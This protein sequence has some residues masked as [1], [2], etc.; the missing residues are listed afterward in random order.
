MKFKSKLLAIF[1]T[2]IV[3]T[4]TVDASPIDDASKYSVRIKSNVRYA[5]AEEDAGTSDGAGFLIDR[6]RGW[7]L[8]NAH[9][10][11]YG[12]GDIEVSFKGYDYFDAKPVYIDPELDLAIVQVETENIPEE[13]MEAKLSCGDRALNGLAVAAYGHPHGLT[14]SASRGIISKVRYYEGVDWVQ[15]DAAVNPGNSGGPLIDLETGDVVGINA[16]GLEDTEGLNFA[17]PAKPVCKV[18]ELMMANENPSPPELPI[19]FAVNEESEE[20]LIVGA[21]TKGKL[22]EGFVLGD[23]IIN[24]DGQKVETPTTLK[25]N[26]RGK[27]GQADV[28]LKRGEKEVK[29]VLSFLPEPKILDRQYVLADGALIARDVYPERRNLES[30]FL[31]QSVR[32]GSYAARSGWK[33]YRL[34]MSIDG[35]QP[36]SLPQIKELLTG[37]ENKV[38]IF[39]GWSAQ[40]AKLHDYHEVGYWPYKVELKKVGD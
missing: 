16:M 1:L 17:V 18:L 29:A 39:R 27:K 23:R 14:Y 34:I 12:T 32:R 6:K 13:A 30:F 20:Y 19:T 7:V 9:V 2:V 36:T 24:V 11:G 21:G 5:F 8:T 4:P 3:W 37:D 35:I 28:V 40:S 15:T 22:P 26:L 25:T 38:I 33:K 10:S 31:V